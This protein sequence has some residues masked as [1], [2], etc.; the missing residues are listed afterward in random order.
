[1]GCSRCGFTG[2]ED[3]RF[4]VEVIPCDRKLAELFETS[5]TS[6]ELIEKLAQQGMY[7]IAEQAARFL[8]AGEISPDT[9]LRVV[10]A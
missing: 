6:A 9:Y 4:Q 1:M 7:T 5:G 3:T 2:H 10:T 8:V